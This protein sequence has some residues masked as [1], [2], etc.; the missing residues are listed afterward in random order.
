M[1]PQKESNLHRIIR[2]DLLY[3][4]SYGGVLEGNYVSLPTTFPTNVSRRI[5][6]QSQTF[7]TVVIRSLVSTLMRQTR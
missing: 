3:P 5:I 6:P 4:L 1:Y 7:A 2:S